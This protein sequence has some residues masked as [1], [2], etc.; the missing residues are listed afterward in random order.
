MKKERLNNLRVAE[1]LGMC[2]TEMY[3][4]I[5]EG[6]LPITMVTGN[7]QH[8]T[9]RIYRFMLENFIGRRLNKEELEHLI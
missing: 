1:F 5:L 8:H 6:V 7:E 2:K 4:R 3:R 9:Y